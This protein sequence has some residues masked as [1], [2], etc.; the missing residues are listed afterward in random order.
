MKVTIKIE[1]TSKCIYDILCALFCHLGE[2][3]LKDFDTI[4]FTGGTEFI[5]FYR[6]SRVFSG[7]YFLIDDNNNVSIVRPDIVS[8]IE[9]N[10]DRLSELINHAKGDRKVSE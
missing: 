6:N 10:H 3:S 9:G 4:R 8:F 5:A 1:N 7:G 2:E